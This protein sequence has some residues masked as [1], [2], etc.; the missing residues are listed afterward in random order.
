MPSSLPLRSPNVIVVVAEGRRGITGG[1]RPAARSVLFVFPFCFFSTFFRALPV[2][3][4]VVVIFFFF[5]VVAVVVVFFFFL[6]FFFFL[7]C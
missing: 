4:V 3:V 5:V 7:S 6:F 1:N 2:V